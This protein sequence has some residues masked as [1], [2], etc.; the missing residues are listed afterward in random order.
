[1]AQWVSSLEQNVDM[2]ANAV[3]VRACTAHAGFLSAREWEG[4]P[5]YRGWSCISHHNVALAKMLME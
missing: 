3:V 1:M 5:P 4:L 2:G